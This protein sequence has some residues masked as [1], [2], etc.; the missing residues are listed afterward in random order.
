MEE[1]QP[2][3]EIPMDQVLAE[4]RQMLTKEMS[5]RTSSPAES[6]VE[7][8]APVQAKPVEKCDY[9]LLEPS[10]RCDSLFKMVFTPV[11]ENSVTPSEHLPQRKLNAPISAELEVWL[12]TNL[13]SMIEEILSKRK[14]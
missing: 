14:I 11:P 8:S 12:K 6:T 4:I 3:E 2:P 13:P 7:I 10:M 9:F 1:E 5:G